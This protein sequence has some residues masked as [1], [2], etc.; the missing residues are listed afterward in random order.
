M[1]D[2]VPLPTHFQRS[3]KPCLHTWQKLHLTNLLCLICSELQPLPMKGQAMPWLLGS[4]P[5]DT[6][7]P[8]LRQML[9]CVLLRPTY[10]VSRWV[11]FL[12]MEVFWFRVQDWSLCACELL[13]LSVGYPWTSSMQQVSGWTPSQMHFGIDR[14]KDIMDAGYLF[15]SAF[16]ILCLGF[17]ILNLNLPFSQELP[18]SLWPS[19]HKQ[20]TITCLGQILKQEIHLFPAHLKAWANQRHDP[21][22]WTLKHNHVIQSTLTVLWLSWQIFLAPETRVVRDWKKKKITSG[23]LRRKRI[24]WLAYRQTVAELRINHRSLILISV[25]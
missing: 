2:E 21:I 5:G 4:F 3:F 1:G 14:L 13:A 19:L 8:Y 6:F 7:N 10:P 23:K 20:S 18:F 22:P 12:Q 9:R 24:K 16:W 11:N 17:L 25:P 15:T